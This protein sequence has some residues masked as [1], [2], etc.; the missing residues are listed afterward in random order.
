MEKSYQRVM[1][2]E[3]HIDFFTKCKKA[4]VI[5]KG[6]RMKNTTQCV[7]NTKL[8]EFTMSKMRN[9]ILEWQHKQL[10]FILK[11]TK[12]EEEILK[13]YM[14]EINPQR[15]HINDLNW[16]NKHDKKRKEMMLE[17]HEKKLKS[18]ISQQLRKK[19]NPNV[20]DDVSNVVNKS[21][22][23]LNEIHKVVLSKGL[24]FVPTQRSIKVI[25][26]IA[27]VEQALSTAPQ[28]TKQTAM[29]EISTFIG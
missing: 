13:M 23:N 11:E 5:P 12:T 3:L 22:R 6:I 16:I 24:K 10:K 17:K 18:L 7:R 9:N 29:S 27:N 25:D 26:V 21:K 20:D 2:V 19:K 4:G 1:K 15:D 8:I 14:V 28:L